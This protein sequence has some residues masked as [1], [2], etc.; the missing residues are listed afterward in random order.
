[1]LPITNRVFYY[2]AAAPVLP[3][4]GI[5]GRP[6]LSGRGNVAPLIRHYRASGFRVL[7]RAYAGIRP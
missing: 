2:L 7:L 1:M 3:C 4:A 5:P 6:I